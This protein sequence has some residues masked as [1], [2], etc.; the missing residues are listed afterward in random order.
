MPF[1]LTVARPYAKA[2]LEA[3]K[4]TD[5]LSYWSSTL[6]VL[7]KIIKNE[8][9]AKIISDP[10]VSNRQVRN[11]LLEL[12][13]EIDHKATCVP[14]KRVENLIELLMYEKRLFALPDIALLYSAF[15]D[16]YEGVTEVEV[17]SVFSLSSQKLELIKKK[18]EKRFDTKVKLKVAIDKSLMGGAII[19]AGSW[20]MDGSIRTKINRLIESLKE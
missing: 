14:M 5:E 9:I 18:L 10:N 1:H 3:A 15:L 19:R 11:L 6:H 7:S 20:V 8:S 13:C 17:I 4:E 12:L 2:L 16:D